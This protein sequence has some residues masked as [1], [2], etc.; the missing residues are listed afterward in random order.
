MFSWFFPQ[1]LCDN[2]HLK[3]FFSAGIFVGLV[4][5]TST[6]YF[7]G[8]RLEGQHSPWEPWISGAEPQGHKKERKADFL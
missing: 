6:S 7:I 4:G 3:D 8:D 5:V 2:Q 1:M